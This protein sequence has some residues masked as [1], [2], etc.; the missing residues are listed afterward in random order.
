MKVLLLAGNYPPE[1]GGIGELVSNLAHA[2][3]SRGE[4]V[5]V[6][7]PVNGAADAENE[8]KVTEFELAEKGYLKRVS[9]CRRTL[10]SALR[11]G[12]FDRVLL[13]SWSPFAVGSAHRAGGPGIDI[14]C[15]GLDLLEPMS[16]RR[17]RWLMR[18]TLR[19]ASRI[20]ANSRYT[21]GL[22]KSAG[23]APETVRVIHPGVDTLRFQPRP[24]PPRLREDTSC[25]NKTVLLTVTRLVPR[26]GVD[27][28]IGILPRLAHRYPDLIYLV[29]GDGPERSRLEGLAKESGAADRIAFLGPPRTE[30]LPSLYNL[31]DIF[32]MPNRLIE[33]QGDVEGFGIVFLEAAASAVPAVGGDSGGAPDAIDDGNTGF[34]VT[35]D[36][37]DELFDKLNALLSDPA[38]R[39][40]MGAAGRQRAVREFQWHQI[41]AA[42]CELPE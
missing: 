8:L 38:L 13:S 30:D 21:A 20:I 25:A 4:T 28:V 5:E 17:Y 33:E 2:L 42:Y 7:T 22:A 26:K 3:V 40:Q 41:A 27:A 10:R 6:I 1:S 14:L 9:R 15:H 24:A 39:E 32:V 16:S 29:A 37:P 19:G 12:D 36:S 18:R 34:V 35:P 23:A 31:A 11:R